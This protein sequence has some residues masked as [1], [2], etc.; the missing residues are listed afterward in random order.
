M[1]EIKLKGLK[2]IPEFGVSVASPKGTI[3]SVYVS[4][5]VTDVPTL[6]F[7]PRTNNRKR[8]TR[9]TMQPF[10]FFSVNFQTWPI[11]P[12]GAK[13][14]WRAT[15]ISFQYLWDRHKLI[16]RIFAPR[17]YYQV[18]VSS[19]MKLK[20]WNWNSHKLLPC[21]EYVLNRAWFK[22]SH[23]SS[24]ILPQCWIHYHIIG[25]IHDINVYLIIK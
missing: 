24:P 23:K 25:G 4:C 9:Y 22:T 18:S 16:P 20:L 10:S 6:P 8:A 15:S 7:I 14:K 13:T 19:A 17:C 5:A 2:V 1:L 12:H 11:S 3:S 21:L